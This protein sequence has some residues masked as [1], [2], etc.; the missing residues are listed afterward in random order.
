[1][2]YALAKLNLELL[3]MAEAHGCLRLETTRWMAEKGVMETECGSLEIGLDEAT[4]MA[5]KAQEKWTV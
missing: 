5:K 3:E 4:S 1:M 2:R